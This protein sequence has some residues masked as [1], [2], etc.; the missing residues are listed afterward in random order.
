M[1][2]KN[3]DNFDEFNQQQIKAVRRSALVMGSAFLLVAL[4]LTALAVVLSVTVNPWFWIA[5]VVV[6]GFALI[7]TASL[8]VTCLFAK[9]LLK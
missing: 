1:S 5:V 4:A 2:L 8:I 3:F 6:G 9:S 7:Y